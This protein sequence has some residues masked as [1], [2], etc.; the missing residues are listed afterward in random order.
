MSRPQDKRYLIITE[1]GTTFRIE[2]GSLQKPEDSFS[3]DNDVIERSFT[4]GAIIPGESRG[5]S[6]ELILNVAINNQSES[7][8]RDIV[9]NLF[10]WCRKAVTIRDTVNNIETDVRIS[11]LPIEYDEGGQ[12]LGSTVSFVFI[13]LIPFWKDV[14]FIE[15]SENLSL[16]NQLVIDNDGYY[17]TPAIFIIQTDQEIPKF[18]IKMQETNL[19][20]GINDLNFGKVNL[21]TYVIDNE[22][23]EALLSTILRNDRII[24]GTGFFFLRRGTNT[25]NVTTWLN[26]DIDFTVR[27]K[28]RFFI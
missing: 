9:N 4:D 17:D 8:Y 2:N 21:Q 5:T 24:S 7:A 13:Q 16:S 25:L 6:K 26:R 1:D 19:G 23:G 28:R 20:I 18:L 10:Y 14:N 22:N 12:H 11:E 27:Y 3:I 15:V